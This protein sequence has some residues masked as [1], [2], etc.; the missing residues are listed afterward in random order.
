MGQ[1]LVID[2]YRV[3]VPEIEGGQIA[4]EDLLRLDIVGAAP[5]RVS[6]GVRVVEQCVEPGI[7][8]VT[9]IRALGGEAG[10]R[11][12]VAEN[13]RLLVAADP[14]QRIHL[15]SSAGHVG[16]KRSVLGTAQIERDPHVGQLLLHHGG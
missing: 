10:S 6:A 13:I 3:P 1:P 7:R 4:G 15:K 9:A 12:D 11:E 8:V 2:H 5:G 14:A 16:V